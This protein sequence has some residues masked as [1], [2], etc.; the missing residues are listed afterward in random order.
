MVLN[1]HH[2]AQQCSSTI[3][4]YISTSTVQELVMYQWYSTVLVQL[5]YYGR[6]GVLYSCTCTSTVVHLVRPSEFGRR[7]YCSPGVRKLYKVPQCTAVVL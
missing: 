5:Y 1:L 6:T 7:K 2:V 4:Y 3:I